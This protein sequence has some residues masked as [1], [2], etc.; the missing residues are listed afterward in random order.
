MVETALLSLLGVLEL[1]E[2]VRPIFL[3]VRDANLQNY[4]ICIKNKTK[5]NRDNKEFTSLETYLKALLNVPNAASL[6][7]TSSSL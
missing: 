1:N 6:A 3:L 7:L 2:N 4:K 5:G